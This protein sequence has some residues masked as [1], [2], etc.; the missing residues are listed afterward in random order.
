M[1]HKVSIATQRDC[2]RTIDSKTTHQQLL[3]MVMDTCR[4][5]W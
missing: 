2:F 4:Q 5:E 1:K 3:P